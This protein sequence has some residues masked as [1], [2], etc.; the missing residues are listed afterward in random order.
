MRKMFSI[1][2]ALFLVLTFMVEPTLTVNAVSQSEIDNAVSRAAAYI[3][4]NIRNPE[5][6]SEWAILG[7]ARSNQRIP[8]TYFNRYFRAVEQYVRER[9]GVLDG[10]RFT[11]YS[12][13]IIA[14]TAA[15]FDPRNVA[16]F[17]LTVSL[18]DFERTIWQGVNGSIFA[19][20]ALDSLNYT[21]PLNENAQTQA[22]REMYIAEILRQ[23][24]TDGGWSLSGDIGDSD[25]TGMALQ[26]LA[27]YQENSD[28]AVAIDNALAFLSNTQNNNG[29]FSNSFSQ[30]PNLESS[31]QVLVALTELGLPVDDPRFVKNGNT[32]LDNIL[33]FQ[34][35]D[36][37]FSHSPGSNESNL[38]STSQALYGLVAAQRAAEGRNSLY[39]MS[40]RR[41]R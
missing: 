23:Q 24:N 37:S 41:V 39:R 36:G 35:R 33:S 30:A 34:N 6:G 13:V 9:N 15:G 20:L 22:S 1:F 17:D 14:L 18:G 5:I 12:R 27:K 40:D 25:I 21:I 7:L 8:D 4:R 16:G 31:V 2:I 3:Q 29:G 10:R 19:L 26:A 11:E 38:I 32:I 28:V